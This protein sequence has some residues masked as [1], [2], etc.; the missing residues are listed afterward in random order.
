MKRQFESVP[1]WGE[2]GL[3][4]VKVP[5]CHVCGRMKHLHPRGVLCAPYPCTTVFC[6]QE[7]KA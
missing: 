4:W 5:K 1:V 6:G 3:R 2:S 7:P